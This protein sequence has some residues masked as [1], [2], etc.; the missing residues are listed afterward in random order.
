MSQRILIIDDDPLL[1]EIASELL[2]T[3]GYDCQTAEDGRVGLARL[4]AGP[5]DLVLLDMIMP[6][7]DGVETLTAI[8]DR[9]PDLPVA[10]MS[11]GT[12]AMSL[13]GLLRIAM[14]L[15]ASEALQKPLSESTVLPVVERLLQQ[16]IRAA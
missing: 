3:A 1:R 7:M 2:T 12:R 5:V 11:A 10:V 13:Q 9:W 15:G 14:G 16:K 4:E 6:N 8:R